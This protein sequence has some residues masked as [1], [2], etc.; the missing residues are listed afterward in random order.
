MRSMEHYCCCRYTPDQV[1]TV[2]C[3]GKSIVAA[4]RVAHKHHPLP[5]AH[6][7]GDKV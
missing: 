2:G 4:Q 7:L 5:A 6:D 1:W 3:T